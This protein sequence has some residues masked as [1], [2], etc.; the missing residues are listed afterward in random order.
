MPG[1]N[2]TYSFT[3]VVPWPAAGSGRHIARPTRGRP[4][5]AEITVPLNVVTS[6]RPT[7]VILRAP[8]HPYARVLIDAVP[9][10]DPARSG[11]RPRPSPR[12]DRSLGH[13][14]QL[15]VGDRRGMARTLRQWSRDKP[16]RSIPGTR[17]QPDTRSHTLYPV[18]DTRNPGQQVYGLGRQTRVR[19]CRI[20]V[21]PTLWSR[22][23]TGF[24]LTLCADLP[25]HGGAVGV[26]PFVSFD[27]SQLLVR[28]SRKL[29]DDA[30]R[31]Q[32]VVVPNR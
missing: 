19:G 21:V 4:D 27:F 18:T 23:G 29:I 9:P 31:G 2:A 20:C 30:A 11:T 6:V 1:Y 14:T 10:V 32:A 28:Q 16:R 26:C 8:R 22:R 24:L 13:R 17:S 7:D 15:T 25:Q 12:P 3:S 5:A